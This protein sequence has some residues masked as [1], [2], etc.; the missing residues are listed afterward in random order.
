MHRHARLRFLV[1]AY[2]AI[3]A[4]NGCGGD[5][6]KRPRGLRQ[7]QD[8]WIING[9]VANGG[10]QGGEVLALALDGMRYRS[11]IAD[12]GSFGVQLPGNASYAF[13]FLEAHDRGAN[14]SDNIQAGV[15]SNYELGRQALL[16]YEESP[17]VGVRNTLRLPKVLF[18]NSI[19]LGQI[20]IKNGQAFPTINPAL[21]L[22]F[23]NDGMSDFADIDDQNDGLGDLDQQKATERIQICHFNSEHQGKTVDVALAELYNHVEDG[24]TLGPCIAM[25]DSAPVDESLAEI[26]VLDRQKAQAAP[27]P[28]QSP[29]H[30]RDFT[31]NENEEES[32]DENVSDDKETSKEERRRTR[33]RLRAN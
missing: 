1:F 10:Y 8:N 2:F 25:R 23:D 9:Q 31:N 24:D 12:D 11:R 4:L 18:N 7:N 28:P 14:G 22:D 6:T 29:L 15:H 16:T 26:E 5:N 33:I 20:D 21:T 27:A 19:S 32:G 3:T 13:H 17:D 30:P